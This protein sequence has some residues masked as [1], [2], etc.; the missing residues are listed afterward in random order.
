MPLLRNRWG[1]RTIIVVRWI[2]PEPAAAAAPTLW[3]LLDGP[4]RARADRFRF[5]ADRD[6]YVTAHALLRVTLS[7]E[8]EIA[9]ADW[10][11]RTAHGGKPEIDPALG[12]PDLRF[13]LSHTRGMVAC[14]VGR[15]HDLG[16]D[17]EACDPSYPALEVAQRFF[18]PAEVALLGRLPPAQRNATF[19]RIW[20]L[21]EAY[22]KATGQ[23]IV[24]PL[25]GFAFSLDPVSIEFALPGSDQPA[26]WQFAELWTGPRYRLALAVRHPAAEPVR[27]D[28][29][30]ASLADCLA[31]ADSTGQP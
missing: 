18:A 2:I 25:D 12:Q 26:A 4:E 7:K 29:A 22:L 3:P 14:A 24:G 27:L 13:S 23:G 19:Y 28:P 21:K 8:A 5:S 9:A 31:H 20:T 30:P 17:V 1:Y 16:V 10:R 11:F 15:S 6:A